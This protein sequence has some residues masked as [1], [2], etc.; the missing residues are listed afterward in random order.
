[1]AYDIDT[2]Y[3]VAKEIAPFSLDNFLLC[4]LC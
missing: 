1:M 2:G 4:D 3:I